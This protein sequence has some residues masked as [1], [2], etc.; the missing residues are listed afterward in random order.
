MSETYHA[1]HL[2][3]RSRVSQLQLAPVL[4]QFS[5]TVVQDQEQLLRMPDLGNCQSQPVQ[6]RHLSKFPPLSRPLLPPV[7]ATWFDRNP[8]RVLYDYARGSRVQIRSMGGGGSHRCSHDLERTGGIGR[9]GRVG[10]RENGG[11]LTCCRAASR[12]SH[13][14]DR[15]SVSHVFTRD[16]R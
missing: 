13:Q 7:P 10:D 9:A 16:V 15:V 14:K 4:Y 5:Y 1:H 8:R 11:M 2:P 6:R 3:S 12:C